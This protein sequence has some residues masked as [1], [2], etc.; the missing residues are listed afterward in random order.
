MNRYRVSTRHF[1]LG[2]ALLLFGYAA[3]I[4]VI[5]PLQHYRKASWYQPVFTNQRFINPGLAKHYPYDTVIIGTSMTENFLPSSVDSILGV[6][7]LKLSIEGAS[8]YEQRIMLQ[9]A[10][11]T[12]KVKQVIWGVDLLTFEGET[13]RLKNGKGSLPFYLFD[14][15]LWNDYR[16]LLN[17]DIAK[18]YLSKIALGNLFGMKAYRQPLE[19]FQYWGDDFTPEAQRLYARAEAFAAQPQP[20]DAAPLNR[21]YLEGLENSM[22]YNMA[23]II[24]ENPEIRFT[25][26][27]PPYSA[28]FWAERVQEKKWNE[29]LLF[30]R[31]IVDR[32]LPFS[33]VA[34][35]DFQDIEAVTFDFGHYKDATHYAPSVNTF[36]LRA[37]KEG[38][39]RLGNDNAGQ[40]IGALKEQI[41]RFP[42]IMRQYK[43]APASPAIRGIY[44]Q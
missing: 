44:E 35:Y 28:L 16:Y 27:F 17:I 19:K 40:K 15:T 20:H 13:Q 10:I 33:N 22:E 21:S 8:A 41:A 14:D 25:L 39:Y 38:T 32:L 29:L 7:S 34:L 4:Y 6:H 3:A 42:E 36:M 23:E 1:L 18:K 2:V 30:K 11:R 43:N 9:T 5:D 12:G 31:Y 37:F 24:R 26:F